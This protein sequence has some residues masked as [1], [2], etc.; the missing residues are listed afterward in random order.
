MH[1]LQTAGKTELIH[2]ENPGEF[3]LN[4]IQNGDLFRTEDSTL[5]HLPFQDR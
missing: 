3:C 4:K 5:W 2:K 1:I